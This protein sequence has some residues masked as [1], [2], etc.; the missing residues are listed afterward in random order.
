MR[1]AR[2]GPIGQETPVALHDGRAF[3][4]RSI[5]SDVGAEL[6]DK[7]DDVRAAL[8]AGTLP[9]ITDGDLRVG[10]PIARPGA[11]VCIGM[12]YAAHAAESGSAPPE[13]PVI[14]FKHPNTV[15]G[16][17]D[18]VPLPDH[19]KKLDWEVELA[20]VVGKPVWMLESPEEGRA[21]I[22]GITVADDLSE[23]TWQIEISGGQWSK[24]KAT[25]GSTP[26]GPVLVTPDEVD[27]DN[28]RLTSSVNGEPRQESSTSD[29]IFDV[30]TIVY[31][32]SQY[33]QLDAGDLILTGTPEG[34]AL[35]GR[36][37]YLVD[38]DVVEM[39]IEGL[40]SQR[41]IVRRVTGAR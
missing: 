14:F 36:F 4:I 37:P 38:G 33:M 13:Q 3:D 28:L 17:D 35:S 31:E 30:G 2:L 16:P 9:E 19:A 24:G 5:A 34:V 15:V 39:G 32:L 6:F 26:L 29:L 20:L 25:P 10:A 1:F 27:I 8:D 18:D 11:V 21:A 22:A 40:G 12:N 7:L 23:R 41:H